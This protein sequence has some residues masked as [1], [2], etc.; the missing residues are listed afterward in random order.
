MVSL[1]LGSCWA[2][3]DWA[4]ALLRAYHSSSITS[5]P[6]ALLGSCLLWP[7][8]INLTEGVDMT[9]S[10]TDIKSFNWYPSHPMCKGAKDP[11]GPPPPTGPEAWRVSPVACSGKKPISHRGA[12][13]L[14]HWRMRTSGCVGVCA[15][16]WTLVS[17]C[18][19]LR[20]VEFITEHKMEARGAMPVALT[21]PAANWATTS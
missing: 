18:A 9:W 12:S 16:A 17:F 6:A 10:K 14:R 15:G 20:T 7:R 21:P 13:R 5:S 11:P 1:T 8:P 2:R 3:G 4:R 19:L